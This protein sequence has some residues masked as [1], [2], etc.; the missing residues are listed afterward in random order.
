MIGQLRPSRDSF[1]T[2]IFSG[3]R[4]FD[5]LLLGEG[6]SDVEVVK[7]V[8]RKLGLSTDKTLAVTDCEGIN[9]LYDMAVIIT[10]LIK[11]F[12]R[13]KVLAIIIDA[14]ELGIRG[15]LESL[16]DSINARGYALKDRHELAPQ[17]F[18][19]R[20]KDVGIPIYVAVNGVEEYNFRKH[21]LEDH[22]LKLLELKG[23]VERDEFAHV[24]AAKEYLSSK[25]YDIIEVV[26]NS[27]RE[28]VVKALNHITTL[29]NHLVR[30]P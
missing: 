27:S 11:F 25:S 7:E 16:V 9:K 5:I 10:A 4:K 30:D 17:V 1:Y 13:V 2:F 23:D 19:L 29:L 14:N 12:R 28:E 26:R 24:G 18:M 15:R 6:R 3:T 21:E 8:I 20:L 22:I